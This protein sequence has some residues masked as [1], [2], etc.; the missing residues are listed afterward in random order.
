MQAVTGTIRRLLR[1]S[2]GEV[3]GFALDTGLNIR[4]PSDQAASM[5]AIV[6]VGSSVKVHASVRGNPIGTASLA[7]VTNLDSG[8]SADFLAFS[9]AH[10]PEVSTDANAPPRTEASLAP[11]PRV[12]CD[13]QPLATARNVADEI[14]Q[15]YDRLHRTQAMLAY[16]VMMRQEQN[17]IGQYLDEAKH[18]Y[19]QALSRHQVR[20]FE[21]ARDFAAA[22]SGLSRVV[23]ILISRTFHSSINYPKLVPP[24]PEHIHARRDEEAARHDLAGAEQRFTRVHWVT[25]NGTL[26]SEDRAQVEKLLLWS[27]LL[28]RWARR[29]LE[30]G[31]VEDAVEFAQAANAAVCSAEHLCRKCYTA[32][33]A[34]D[35]H[36]A[37]ASS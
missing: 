35:R 22:S 8:Q 14:E 37:A 30:T 36:P 12:V 6:T 23:E 20:D 19:V 4:F 27:H 26:T 17:M 33:S 9:P 31:A 16:L 13:P 11:A 29:L 3:N 7:T 18:T 15:A 25:E 28:S 10:K 21:G 1:D 34:D 32:R 24:P 2:A 5:L